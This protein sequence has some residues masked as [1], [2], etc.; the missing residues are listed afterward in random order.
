MTMKAKV[1]L[2]KGLSHKKRNGRSFKRGEAQTLTNPAEIAYYKIQPDFSVVMLAGSDVQKEQ[3]P[4][5][6]TEDAPDVVVYSQD[7]LKGF[8]KKKLIEIADSL[9]V[10]VTG[11]EKKSEII[12]AI[13]DRQEEL[14]DDAENEEE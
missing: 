3:P 5:P 2:I 7:K 1:S 11:E 9:E 10:L 14:A 4:A 8:K 6:D 12:E 13:L